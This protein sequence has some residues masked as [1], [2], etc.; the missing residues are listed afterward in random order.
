MAQ[1]WLCSA[2]AFNEITFSISN[3]LHELQSDIQS[4]QSLLFPGRCV[5]FKP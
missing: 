4:P 1:L 3:S 2:G 5:L